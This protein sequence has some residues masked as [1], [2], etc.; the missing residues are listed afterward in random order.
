MVTFNTAKRSGDF[1]VLT[2]SESALVVG[3]QTGV[4]DSTLTTV[5][6]FTATALI[7]SIT[8][9]SCSGQQSAKWQL[10]IDT[11]LIDTKRT[12]PG[13]NLEFIFGNH[14]GMSS[15]SVLDVK[16]THYYT[17]ETPDF[18]STIYGF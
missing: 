16:V 1:G 7:Q 18:E 6:T 3:S 14:L 2:A 8:N 15:G 9:I 11:V 4:V 10:Y 12:A 13:L 17:G 5:A